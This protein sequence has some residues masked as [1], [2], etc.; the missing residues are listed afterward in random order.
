MSEI[1]IDWNAIRPLNDSRAK[2]FE[3]LCAQLARAESPDGSRFE[4]KGTP[5]AGVECYAVLEDSNEWGWQA[6]YLNRFDNS[7]WS[8]IDQSVKKALDKH[9]RLVTYFI[10]VPLDR[11][12]ARISGQMSAKERWNNHVKKWTSWASS[13]SMTVDFVYWGSFQL[14]ERLARPQHIGRV[15]FWFDI[16]GFDMA[17]FTARLDEALKTAGPRYTP[18]INVDL[19]IAGELDA[20]GRT[21]QFFDQIKSQAPAIRKKLRDL[22]YYRPKS[23]EQA[24]NAEISKLSSAVQAILSELGAVTAQPIGILPLKRIAESVN[25][26]VVIAS[27]LANLLLEFERE[28][29]AKPPVVQSNS[30]TSPQRNNPFRECRYVLS[31]LL[32]V[33]ENTYEILVHTDRVASCSLMLLSGD[34]GTGKTEGGMKHYRAVVSQ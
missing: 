31:T 27:S 8:E 16:H 13:R 4:R 7:A 3:E 34:A 21:E 11:P 24:L 17:W 14:L 9:P 33:L 28:H 10:C 26:A 1:P 15:R 12:D 6:K 18:E 23:G 20:F 19:P 5:D 2:G 25:A 32:S 22:E 30:A 29:D